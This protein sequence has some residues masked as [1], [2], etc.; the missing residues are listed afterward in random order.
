MKLKPSRPGLMV[1][2]PGGGRRYLAA[3]GAELAL[4]TYWRRRLNCGDV[5]EV[6]DQVAPEPDKPKRAKRKP[7]EERE[8]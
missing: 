1:P 2:Y 3:E 6:V 8:L 5:V 7:P 4:N